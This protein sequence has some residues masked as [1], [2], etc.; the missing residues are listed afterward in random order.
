[1]ESANRQ[2]HRI[3]LRRGPDGIGIRATAHR[4]ATG[5][6]ADRRPSLGKQRSLAR[7]SSLRTAPAA[8]CCAAPSSRRR[9]PRR[10]HLD[11]PSGPPAL[12]LLKRHGT[13]QP[14]PEDDPH[15]GG[16]P[17]ARQRAVA[18]LD[19]IRRC[20]RRSGDSAGT[21][22]DRTCAESPETGATHTCVTLRPLR[23][24]WSTRLIEPARDCFDQTRGPRDGTMYTVHSLMV[25]QAAR[26]ASS[27]AAKLTVSRT[28]SPAQ[29][30]RN[31]KP[32]GRNSDSGSQT[33]WSRLAGER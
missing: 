12:D 24:A 25:E 26:S 23:E 9:S 32:C 22:L 33:G 13:R 27:S 21:P 30:A 8:R 5:P 18:T 15:V 29:V 6:G 10:C 11:R 20:S 4:V 3:P 1:M 16:T 7:W 31:R 17:S 14:P 19:R 28:S 2:G